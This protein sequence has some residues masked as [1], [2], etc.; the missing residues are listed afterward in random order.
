VRPLIL[1]LLLAGLAP[2]TLRADAAADLAAANAAWSAGQA[3]AA[4]P[5]YQ[6]AHQEAPLWSAPLYGQALCQL[7][8]D[9]PA[10]ALAS[11]DEALRLEPGLVAAQRLRVEALARARRAVARPLVEAADLDRALGRLEAAERGYRLALQA[12]PDCAEAYAGLARLR[13]QRG[14][15]G[16]AWQDLSA[17]LRLAPSSDAALGLRNLMSLGPGW[18]GLGRADEHGRWSGTL[19]SGLQLSR[20]SAGS[21]DRD[22]V[23]GVLFDQVGWEAASQPLDLGYNLMDVTSDV[24]GAVSSVIYQSVSGAYWTHGRGRPGLALLLDEALE[25]NQGAL[26]YWHHLVDLRWQGHPVGDWQP[27]G[28]LQAL[29]ENYAAMAELDSFSPSA[30]LGLSGPLPGSGQ[31]QGE[32]RWR[33][34]DTQA[35]D[36]H[37]H[38]ASLHLAAQWRAGRSLSPRLDL[39][40]KVQAF[41]LWPGSAGGRLDRLFDARLELVAWRGRHASAGLVAEGWRRESSLADQAGL[42]STEWV[43]ASWA[44]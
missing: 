2:A 44:W 38:G 4:L 31:V 15:A 1:I 16:N 9:R 20:S 36:E 17:A 14:D 43:G 18:T 5:L 8:L 39:D 7:Q 28:G 10:A 40:A 3:G 23:D 22:S 25:H 30:A 26:A 24:A 41:P 6:Q 19:R 37:D 12:D 32:A 34:D 27:W 33:L 11:L 13:W 42:G 29:W 21:T 35:W